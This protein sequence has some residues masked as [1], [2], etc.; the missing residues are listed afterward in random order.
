M[1]KWLV[2]KEEEEGRGVKPPA[3]L[4]ARTGLLRRLGSAGR[5]Y[6]LGGVGVVTAAV[7]VVS[8]LSWLAPDSD[9]PMGHPLEAV[10]RVAGGVLEQVDDQ[11]EALL[12]TDGRT[13]LLSVR[14]GLAAA[15]SATPWPGNP[16]G[17]AAGPSSNTASPDSESPLTDDAAA[18]TREETSSASDVAPSQPTSSTPSPSGPSETPTSTDAPSS[19]VTS[20]PAPPASEEP[21]VAEEPSTPPPATEEPPAAEEPVPPAEEPVPPP[22]EEPPPV[23]EEPPPVPS[24]PPPAEESPPTNPDE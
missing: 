18:P 24:D 21:P 3:L 6:V 10:G 4:A 11:V 20:E 23:A 15:S 2:R 17:V 7:V 5:G 16:A 22:A 19:P 13:V 1:L 12:G 14:E 9:R 8:L